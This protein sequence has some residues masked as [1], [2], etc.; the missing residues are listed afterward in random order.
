MTLAIP[1]EFSTLSNCLDFIRQNCPAEH[2]WVDANRVFCDPANDS[3]YIEPSL[4][5]PPGHLRRVAL[6]KRFG[7]WEQ[8]VP[9]YLFRGEP[10]SFESTWT[11]LWRLVNNPDFEQLEKDRIIDAMCF[12]RERLRGPVTERRMSKLFAE[13]CC[14]HY[15]LPTGLIDF[16]SNLDVAASFAVLSKNASKQA[17]AIGV[18]DV[19]GARCGAEEIRFNLVDLTRHPW[20]P[21]PRNQAAYGVRHIES[22]GAADYKDSEC[23]SD[24]GLT[25]YQ[26]NHTANE[27]TWADRTS[28]LLDASTDVMAGLILLFLDEYVENEGPLSRKAAEWLANRVPCTL[29]VNCTPV[30]SSQEEPWLATW[31]QTGRQYPEDKVRAHIIQLWCGEVIEE[32][33]RL[34]APNTVGQADG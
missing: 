16:T 18:L 34:G 27:Q 13:G 21:R 10:A 26:F 19:Q 8:A 5:V 25:W 9:R 4:L 1:R 31:A 24:L 12:V 7:R 15:G 20:T 3:D 17:G 33:G 14:Q 28:G 2:V 11:T 22:S 6:R 30:N 29:L 32:E 23:C